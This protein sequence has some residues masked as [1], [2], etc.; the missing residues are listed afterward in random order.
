MVLQHLFYISMH[1]N[2]FHRTTGARPLPSFYHTHTH[3]DIYIYILYILKNTYFQVLFTGLSFP[4][5]LILATIFTRTAFRQLKNVSRGARPMI[6][7]WVQN[8]ARSPLLYAKYQV[9]PQSLYSWNG[10]VL[11]TSM[12][13]V[14]W[15]GAMVGGHDLEY[16]RP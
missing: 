6:R 10:L 11:L 1:S 5:P 14:S 15:D 12:Y 4:I 16:R 8:I 9:S 13:R 7:V 2:S 3:T